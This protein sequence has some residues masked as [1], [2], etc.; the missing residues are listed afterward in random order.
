MSPI[1]TLA[2]PA[3]LFACALAPPASAGGAPSDNPQI[4][5]AGFV[6]LAGRLA[7]EGDRPTDTSLRGSGS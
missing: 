5:Y 6:E 7:T 1:R 2:L 3:A 4:D